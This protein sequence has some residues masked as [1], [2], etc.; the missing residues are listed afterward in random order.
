MVT[1]IEVALLVAVLALLFGAYRII[2]AVKPFIVNA[3]VG[4]IVLVIASFL[5]IGVEITPIAVLICAVG[6]IPGAILVILLAYLGIA[7]AGMAVP[8]GVL[9]LV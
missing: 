1:T 3:V 6:G 7:F 4:L 8:V 9:A 5:G 2:K